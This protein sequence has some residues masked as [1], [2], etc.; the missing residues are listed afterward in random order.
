[1]QG[2]SSQWWNSYL[3]RMWSWIN[4]FLVHQ[5]HGTYSDIKCLLGKAT[6]LFCLKTEISVVLTENTFLASKGQFVQYVHVWVCLCVCVYVGVTGRT[7]LNDAGGIMSVLHLKFL[8]CHVCFTYCCGYHGDTS[9]FFLV[10][11]TAKRD[12][13]RD[14]WKEEKMH[15]SK[16][17]VHAHVYACTH[18]HTHTYS[19]WCVLKFFIPSQ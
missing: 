14:K 1:M 5:Y 18:A 11:C 8:F 13:E 19:M 10:M 4:S 12:R 2:S 9:L 17:H 3:S 7:A 6:C 15:G 16:K